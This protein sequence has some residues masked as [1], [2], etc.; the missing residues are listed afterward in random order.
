MKTIRLYIVRVNAAE[1]GFESWSRFGDFK[2]FFNGL[3]CFC[4]V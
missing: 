2:Y 3:I 1:M 4:S